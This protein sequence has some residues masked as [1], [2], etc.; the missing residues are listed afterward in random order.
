MSNNDDKFTLDTEVRDWLR[1]HC[2]GDA[3]VSA[4]Q[5]IAKNAAKPRIVDRPD[6]ANWIVKNGVSEKV[7]DQV[8]VPARTSLKSK[9]L[10]YPLGDVLVALL[11]PATCDWKWSVELVQL[12]L[13]PLDDWEA[14]KAGFTEIVWQ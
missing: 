5:E 7:L 12:M 8:R 3:A 10:D 14:T 6:I 1:E 9:Y 11:G 2:F 4:R 13:T